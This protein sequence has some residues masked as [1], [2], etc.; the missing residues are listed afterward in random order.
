MPG[1]RPAL[2][3]RTP[4]NPTNY[5]KIIAKTAITEEPTPLAFPNG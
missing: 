1:R 2:P 3:L 4:I 5:L